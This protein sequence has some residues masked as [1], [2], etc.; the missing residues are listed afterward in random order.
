MVGRNG[1]VNIVL[2]V[3]IDIFSTS[4]VFLYNVQHWLE[5]QTD[6]ISLDIITLYRCSHFKI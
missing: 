2:Y 4:N 6:Q 5:F 3:T 1:F